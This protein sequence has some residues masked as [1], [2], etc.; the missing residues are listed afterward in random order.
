MSFRRTIC[1]LGWAIVSPAAIAGSAENS[2][3]STLA[4][5]VVAAASATLAFVAFALILRPRLVH[6]SERPATRNRA[7]GRIAV[8]VSLA[9][10]LLAEALTGWASIALVGIACGGIFGLIIWTPTLAPR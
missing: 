8:L 4:A 9:G 1:L 6:R 10:T 7:L 3:V 2:N 5:F